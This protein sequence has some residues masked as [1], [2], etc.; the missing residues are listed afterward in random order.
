MA[1]GP[2]ATIGIDVEAKTGGPQRDF[3]KLTQHIDKSKKAAERFGNAFGKAGNFATKAA[4]KISSRFV[5]TAGDVANA[6]KAAARA[7]TGLATEMAAAGDAAA[8][9]GKR[10]GLTAE[11]VQE[12]GHAANLAGSD[13]EVVKTGMMAFAKGLNDALAKGVGPAIQ[14]LGQ[15][16]VSLDDARIR[17]RDLEEIIPLLADKFAALPNDAQKTAIAMK[18]FSRSGAQLIPFLDS[19][20]KGIAAMRQEARDLG[21]VMSNEAAA[22]S[23]EFVDSQARAKAVLIGIRNDAIGPLLPSLTE[24]VEDF[25]QWAKGSDDLKVVLQ[26]SVTVITTMLE[27][28]QALA[29]AF[30]AVGDAIGWVSDKLE[31]E[32]GKVLAVLSG[33]PA[34][35]AAAFFN[36]GPMP[37]ARQLHRGMTPDD[38]DLHRFSGGSDAGRVIPFGPAPRASGPPKPKAKAKKKG[39][40]KQKS[41]LERSLEGFEPTDHDAFNQE[42]RD[43]GLQ[44]FTLQ[45]SDEEFEAAMEQTREFER[46]RSAIQLEARLM[47]IQQAR[48]MGADPI[49]LINAEEEARSR[50]IEF[51]ASK[52]DDELEL[53][54]L[55]N[56]K[57]AVH[58][59]AEIG[60]IE[61][62]RQARA[63]EAAE[64]QAQIQTYTTAVDSAAAAQNF[65]ATA[66][67][68]SEEERARFLA[69]T[70]MVVAGFKA[71]FEQAQALA[72]FATLNIPQGFAH[73]AAALGFAA[74]A[75]EAGR[76]GFA[77]GGGG[78]GT[79]VGR[80][81]APKPPAGPS[82]PDGGGGT[83]RTESVHPL[84]VREGLS[85]S[86]AASPSGSRAGAGT[87]VHHN[88]FHVFGSID[89]ETAVKITRAQQRM[90]REVT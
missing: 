56:E 88:S 7:V 78:G 10:L 5:V 62:R 3:D 63:K 54:R 21:L 36:E 29:P 2:R 40:K 67:I 19:G 75:I 42:L 66:T 77:K 70:Q 50:H 35:I 45:I 37:E 44:P 39:G 79:G 51:L 68:K 31:H 52:T 55:A 13:F 82:R 9:D 84:S 1:R 47:G 64:F 76:S 83:S 53:A 24:A 41:L 30:R 48:D 71:A 4:K 59:Q 6:A 8:K 87:V 89:D 81:G 85:Q 49:E 28:V 32:P 86:A 73:Q 38:P 80:G 20:S 15:L 90:Q 25:A 23:E 22:S 61:A 57:K 69:S 74:A 27:L 17:S 16:G 72:A 58:H 11:A 46:Q 34:A 65:L 33:N 18:L 43:A 12:L 26:Q 14:G 60:R